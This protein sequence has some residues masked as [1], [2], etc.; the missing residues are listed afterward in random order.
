ML[1]PLGQNMRLQ[2]LIELFFKELH[3]CYQGPTIALEQKVDGPW[4][5]T[6]ENLY[7]DIMKETIH[8]RNKSNQSCINNSTGQVRRG[9]NL[10]NEIYY[11]LSHYSLLVMFLDQYFYYFLSFLLILFM[12]QLFMQPKFQNLHGKIMNL[13][14][15]ICN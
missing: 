6:T 15:Q 9:H 5:T 13:L 4:S 2:G 1:N 8:L 11:W 10:L 7:I 12:V 3:L 14:S